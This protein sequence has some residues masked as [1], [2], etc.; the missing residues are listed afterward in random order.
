MD[1]CVPITLPLTNPMPSDSDRTV[2]LCGDW[3]PGRIQVA[4]MR[5][6]AAAFF[7]D[8]SPLI[9]QSDLAGVNI[10]GVAA[11]K[12]LHPLLKDGPHISVDADAFAALAG[13]GFDFG[14]LA[15]NHTY[16]FGSEGLKATIGTLNS[17][18]L[19][20]LGASTDPTPQ[21][22]FSVFSLDGM[23]IGICNVG[24]GEEGRASEHRSGVAGFDVNALS[25]NLPGMRRD[26][27]LLFVIVHAGREYLPLP[28]PGIRKSYRQL[29]DA[30]A[31]LVIGHHP[32]TVQGIEIYK[33]KPIVYSLG[34]FVFP[35]SGRTGWRRLGILLRVRLS[36][37]AI[38][39]LEIWPFKINESG[40]KLL[41]GS[42]ADEFAATF[43]ELSQLIIDTSRFVAFWDAY[44]T[45]WVQRNGIPELMDT[46]TMM[47]SWSAL[48]RASIKLALLQTAVLGTDLASH[49]P[50]R[51]NRLKEAILKGTD[52]L[53]KLAHLPLN[54]SAPWRGYLDS[55]VLDSKARGATALRNRFD[56][57]SHRE[58]FLHG[59]GS[60]MESR[61]GKT[62]PWI[63]EI[64]EKCDVPM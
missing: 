6:D 40:T 57:E 42:E 31:D 47:G 62:E 48:G 26:V 58:M 49:V 29:V 7:G 46:L 9:A 18:G 39:S 22:A 64:L 20:P 51:A 50:N 32:H 27:D 38:A 17:V 59:L 56:T 14:C 28:L 37:N 44:T 55:T 12:G 53:A 45:H 21:A 10:E 19:Y 25:R 61:R 41:V 35:S 15:N 33:D 13:V 43:G 24:E 52:R 8:L 34:N 63:T 3:A 60:I 30:G 2:V 4:A 36:Q 54:A 23:R 1:S 16:D 11:Y 5:S